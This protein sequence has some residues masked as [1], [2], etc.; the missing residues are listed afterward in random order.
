MEQKKKPKNKAT[1]IQ[2]IYDKGGTYIQWKK[3]SST[4][5]VG[6]DGWHQAMKLEHS[7]TI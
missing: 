2:L 3:A 4:Y 6:E 7:H 5:C 1:I